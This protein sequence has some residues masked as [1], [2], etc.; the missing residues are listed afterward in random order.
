M[1]S[2][3]EAKISQQVDCTGSPHPVGEVTDYIQSVKFWRMKSAETIREADMAAMRR[4]LHM[5]ALHH[6]RRWLHAAH[7]DAAVACGI[8]LRVPPAWV[9]SLDLAMTAVALCAL[10]GNTAS[11]VV[12]AAMLRKQ[13]DREFDT[14]QL[15]TSWAA[16]SFDTIRRAPRSLGDR[17]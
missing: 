3:N 12:I 8:A 2:F 7:G 11:A 10:D 17:P 14:A 6:D 1:K 9:F 13:R 5:F 16:K 4:C 15:A